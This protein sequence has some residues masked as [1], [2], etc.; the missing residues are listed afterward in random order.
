MLYKLF[1]SA[2]LGTYQTNLIGITTMDNKA[3]FNTAHSKTRAIVAKNPVLKYRI[4]FSFQ[5]KKAIAEQQKKVT[6]LNADKSVTVAY[7]AK[8]KKVNKKVAMIGDYK[9]PIVKKDSLELPF[10]MMSSILII[11]ALTL[12]AINLL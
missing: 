10:F 5:L 3:I 1:N 7:I 9:K 2:I 6:A 8:P 4:V 11:C 12:Q